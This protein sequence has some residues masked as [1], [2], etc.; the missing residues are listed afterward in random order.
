L[1]K[2][3]LPTS[4]VHAADIPV[5]EVSSSSHSKIQNQHSSIGIQS[6]AG[7]PLIKQRNFPSPIQRDRQF[8]GTDNSKFK[9][10]DKMQLIQRDRQNAIIQ[11]D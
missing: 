2:K 6:V 11:R 7:K 8:K 3:H 9:G 4:V 1:E 5:A 10:T